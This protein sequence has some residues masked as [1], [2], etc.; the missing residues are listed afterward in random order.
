LIAVRNIRLSGRY[1]KAH[2]KSRWNKGPRNINSISPSIAEKAHAAANKARHEL[3]AHFIGQPVDCSAQ[4]SSASRE[5][6]LSVSKFGSV[7]L[8]A[9]LEPLEFIGEL[10]DDRSR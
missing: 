7:S 4:Q 6:G 9:L 1:S 10:V 3:K 8:L 5:K 2:K